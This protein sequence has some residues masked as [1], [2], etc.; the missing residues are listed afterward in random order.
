MPQRISDV[1]QVDSIILREHNVFN[2]FI[3]NDSKLYIDPRLL[4]KTSVI[5][6][7]NADEK[8]MNY[9]ENRIKEIQ[10]IIEVKKELKELKAKESSENFFYRPSPKYLRLQEE[11]KEIRV[12]VR[13][14]LIF[15]E[16]PLAG[17]GYSNK[18]SGGKGIGWSIAWDL[19]DNITSFVEVGLVDPI[20]FQLAAV[21]QKNIGADRI[22]DMII[23]IILPELA[24]FSSRIAEQLNLPKA[25]STDINGN[26]YCNLPCYLDKGILLVPENILTFLPISYL[27]SEKDAIKH[28]NLELRN[29]MNDRMRTLFADGLTWNDIV[30]DKNSLQELL[31]E[32]PDM[33]TKLID[34]Y[35]STKPIPYDFIKDPENLF[36]WHDVAR[37]YSEKYPLNIENISDIYF[38]NSEELLE[39][40]R[41]YFSQIVSWGLCKEFY[42]VINFPQIKRVPKEETIAL[43]ILSELLDYHLKDSCLTVEC[44]PQENVIKF[45]NHDRI[46][47]KFTSS[48]GIIKKCHKLIIENNH[49]N[50]TNSTT[51]LFLIIVNGG[52]SENEI[53]SSFNVNGKNIYIESEFFKI[54]FINARW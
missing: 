19:L 25:D 26:R 4:S 48:R 3:D 1:F 36:S 11:Y 42:N 21:F 35:K 30:K 49:P 15:S 47:L 10:V 54:F 38:I 40:I 7:K 53:R 28:H 17:L 34:T 13:D 32:H 31:V 41:V 14:K 33:M 52:K 39:T 2:G 5:E 37:F 12:E 23:S 29:Y 43:F 6:L 9:F 45:S 16:T 20:I 51:I 24:Q 18:G 27:W 44:V 50:S 8:V 22:S 46:I